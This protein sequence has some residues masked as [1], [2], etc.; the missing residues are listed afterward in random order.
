MISHLIIRHV[1][2]RPTMVLHGSTLF[3][4]RPQDSLA[5]I[6]NPVYLPH[7]FEPRDHRAGRVFNVFFQYVMTLQIANKGFLK[8]EHYSSV[9]RA[10]DDMRWRWTGASLTRATWPWKAVEALSHTPLCHTNDKQS[11]I[12]SECLHFC[13]IN[14]CETVIHWPR[15]RLNELPD[16]PSQFKQTSDQC[17][18]WHIFRSSKPTG[19]RTYRQLRSSL[20]DWTS[21]L[22]ENT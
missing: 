10:G 7:A 17:I 20:G 5:P 6:R 1:T 8:R 21:H 3:K 22:V 9:W 14:L 16:L 15:D 13:D 4:N 12:I 18:A 11:T 19:L 2:G